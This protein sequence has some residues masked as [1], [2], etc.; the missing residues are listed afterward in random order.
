MLIEKFR[1]VVRWGGEKELGCGDGKDIGV[2][3]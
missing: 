2:W 3:F 1:K